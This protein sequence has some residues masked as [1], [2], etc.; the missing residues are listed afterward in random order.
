VKLVVG[1]GNPGP[2]YA[3]TRHNVGFRIAD[4]FA[5]GHEIHFSEERFSGV[6]GSGR[7]AE[8][9]VAL[10]KP[11][12]F[13]NRSGSSVGDAV[14]ALPVGDPSDDLLVIYD[15]LDLPFGRVRVR[16]A[17]GAGGHRGLEDVIERLGTGRFARLR[18]G[19]G[20][21]PEGEDPVK[22]VLTPFSPV[23]EDAL[24]ARIADAARAV[25]CVIEDGVVAAMDRFN[26]PPERD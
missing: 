26:A 10:L 23:E 15:D 19:L 24:V 8:I 6:F 4:C 5:R 18:F 7:V 1:L 17:G 16:P 22:Y 20:R 14:A 25:A 13:M 3:R 21:P 2:R 9:E 11:L 12:T